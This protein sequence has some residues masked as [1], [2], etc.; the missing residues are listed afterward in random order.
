[1]L[2][3]A[4]QHFWRPDRADYRWLTPAIANL[5]RDFLPADLE[6][7]LAAHGIART[8]LVQA[9][10]TVAETYFLLGLAR[11]SGFV[12]GVV[13]WIPLGD[14]RAATMLT[15]MARDPLLVGIRPMLQDVAD[16]QWIAHPGNAAALARC[17]DLGL[18]FDALV[19]PAQLPALAAM[20]R[21]QPT[22]SIVVNHAGKPSIG[23]DLAAWRGHMAALAALPNIWCKL[24]GLATEIEGPISLDSVRPVVDSLLDLFGPD[25]L[26]WGSDWPFATLAI[27][28]HDW[29]EWTDR[30]LAPLSARE[31]AAILGGNAR[32]F[33]RM[34][35]E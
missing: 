18:A 33:Y 21:A 6:P 25:R 2:I 17:A 13:G 20:A 29:R 9:A 31:R 3:D 30:L 23:H 8:I 32:I 34:G 14:P 16:D 15:E 10:P 4:H 35:D 11:A 19:R 22:L 7:L 28:Y 24:S 5:H 27:S 26:I 12:A 1:M